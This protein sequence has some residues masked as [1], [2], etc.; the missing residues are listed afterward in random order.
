MD[1][2]RIICTHRRHLRS[3]TALDIQE[4]LK[5]VEQKGRESVATVVELDGTSIVCGHRGALM[6]V[7]VVPDESRIAKAMEG[8]AS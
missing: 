1:C 7:N 2:V 4:E 8:H 6:Y 5:K 3:Q